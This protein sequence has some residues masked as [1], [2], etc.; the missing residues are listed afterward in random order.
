MV[1]M[2]EDSIL[3]LGTMEADPDF[4]NSGAP[5]LAVIV[6]Y[7]CDRNPNLFIITCPGVGLPPRGGEVA[8]QA[9]HS[10]LRLC[11]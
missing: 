3:P 11:D 8:G 1:D 7:N 6:S 2:E 9:L 4:Q 5:D 10:G